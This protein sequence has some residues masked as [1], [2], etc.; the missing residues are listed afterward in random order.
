MLITSNSLEDKLPEGRSFFLLSC[1]PLPMT[2]GAER[3]PDKYLLTDWQAQTTWQFSGPV[4][5]LRSSPWE[6]LATQWLLGRQAF[7]TG[8]SAFT[9]C[10]L[11]CRTYSS[12]T[13]LYLSDVSPSLAPGMLSLSACPGAPWAASWQ[14][15]TFQTDCPLW[16]SLPRVLVPDVA[17]VLGSSG[18]P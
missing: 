17:L 4:T 18:I 5:A 8:H 15:Q 16:W 9:N 7:L 3:I 1:L 2:W 6:I 12:H 13:H 14:V 10:H 11:A